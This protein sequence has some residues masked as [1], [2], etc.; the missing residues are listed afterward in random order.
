MEAIPP[1]NQTLIPINGVLDP[2]QVV[3]NLEK[4]KEIEREDIEKSKSRNG[5]EI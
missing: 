4:E 5:R 2:L 3:T 1:Q